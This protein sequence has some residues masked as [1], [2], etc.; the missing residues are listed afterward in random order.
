MERKKFVI[1]GWEDLELGKAIYVGQTTQDIWK[2]IQKHKSKSSGCPLLAE[3]LAS[4]PIWFFDVA[5][6]D[7]ADTIEEANRLEKFYI[8]KYDTFAPNGCNMT[9]GGRSSNNLEFCDE[10]RKK[11]S[12]K[13]KGKVRSDE[14]RKRL[15]AALKGRYLSPEHRAKIAK[16][17]SEKVKGVQNPFYGKVH[18]E[19]TKRKIRAARIGKYNGGDNPNA[20]LTQTD[21]RFIEHWLKKGFGVCEIAKEFRVDRNLISRIKKG[22]HWTQKSGIDNAAKVPPH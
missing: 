4:K 20:K 22:N 21:V 19:E 12:E 15:S 11:I 1:Y 8:G 3:R 10:A 2:R 14:T 17:V 7:E 9:R 5:V 13:N 6:L 16:T 18:S